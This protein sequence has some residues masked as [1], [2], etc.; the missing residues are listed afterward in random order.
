[1]TGGG[2]KYA[3][4]SDI[5]G[6]MRK[7]MEQDLDCLFAYYQ[8]GSGNI[9]P[10]SRISSEERFA[11]RDYKLW[12]KAMAD[13][14]KTALNNMTEVNS[15]DVKVLAETY[16]CKSNKVDLDRIDIA[17]KVKDFYLEGH[18]TGETKVYAESLGLASYY[19]A[20]NILM[21]QFSPDSYDL[22][23][24]AISIGDVG[25]TAIP[26]EF[27]DG[28][29]KHIRDNSPYAHNFT[30]SWHYGAYSYYPS[31]EAFQY[32]CYETDTARAQPGTAEAIADRLV[33]MLS[34]LH[35]Q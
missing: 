18:T 19:H 5:V 4:S 31:L 17:Q 35:D 16:I 22:K 24:T 29:M 15:G 2:L 14:A 20:S 11:Q 12:G 6:V 9:N 3:L 1:M 13:T 23:I 10:T 28:T 32:G 7:H 26:G 8:G 30:I 33:E 21:R 34:I 25:I 27:F